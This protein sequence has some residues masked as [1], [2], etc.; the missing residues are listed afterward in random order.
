MKVVKVEEIER[1][2]RF[3]KEINKTPL[4]DIIWTK[5]GVELC[6]SADDIIEYNFTGLSNRDF[7]AVM[8]WLPDDIGIRSATLILK[9]GDDETKC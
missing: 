8:G 6:P 1:C 3:F 9:R 7:P 5:D 2:L 4:E